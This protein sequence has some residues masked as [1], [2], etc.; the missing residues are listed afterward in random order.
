[1][2]MNNTHKA[3]TT[4]KQYKLTEIVSQYMELNDTSKLQ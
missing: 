1:M 4:S 3:T 2:E